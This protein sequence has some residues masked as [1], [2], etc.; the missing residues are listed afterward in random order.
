MLHP[1]Y[2]LQYIEKKWGGEAEQQ[3]EIA[4]GNVGAVNWIAHAREV[5]NNAVH[6]FC[7]LRTAFSTYEHTQMEHYWPIRLGRQTK[8]ATSMAAQTGTGSFDAIASGSGCN[9]PDNDTTSNPESDDN[10]DHKCAQLF[11]S[12]PSNG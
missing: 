4:A 2:K 12:N 3:V 11:N 8:P 5:V 1:Y 10:F 6:L 9:D 7:S